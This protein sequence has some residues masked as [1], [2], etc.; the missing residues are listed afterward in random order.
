MTTDPT[1]TNWRELGLD[2][3]PGKNAFEAA[4]DRRPQAALTPEQIERARK[5]EIE[6]ARWHKNQAL[7]A[8]NQN[9]ELKKIDG[10]R[11]RMLKAATK[12]N[13]GDFH[14][15]TKKQDRA[16]S[17]TTQQMGARE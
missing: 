9:A 11:A 5:N 1:E 6:K 16:Q 4:R 17:D 15:T 3:G 14:I 12:V 8:G 7:K 2:Y 10:I 13:R